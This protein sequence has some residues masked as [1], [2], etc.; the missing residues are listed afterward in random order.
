MKKIIWIDVGTHF[1]QEHSSIF[2]SNYSFYSFIIRRF[3]GGKI[4]KRGKFVIFQ[5]LRD[6]IYSR[7]RI[8]KRSREFFTVFV[9]A[10]PKIAYKKNF[11]PA[12]DMFFN[13]ALTGDSHTPVSI[14]NVLSLLKKTASVLGK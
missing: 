8:R 2:G 7:I 14:A 3:I 4:L 10:N 5:E 13:L 1:A 9:E 12:T 6:I 11:Y